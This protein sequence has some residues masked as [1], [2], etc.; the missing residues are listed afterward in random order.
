MIRIQLLGLSRLAD[1][2]KKLDELKRR[3][4]AD[5]EKV[6][7]RFGLRATATSVKDYLSGPRPEKLGRVTGRLATSIRSKIE[8]SGNKVLMRLGTDVPYARVHELGFSRRVK[9]GK[10]VA[11]RK[12]SFLRPAVMD[13]LDELKEELNE[14]MAGYGE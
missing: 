6:M 1:S 3:V 2:R 7:T 5:L 11:T 10:T 13:N 14:L 8:G 4:T 9:G 12:R